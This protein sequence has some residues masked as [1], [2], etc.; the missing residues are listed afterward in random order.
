MSHNER[1]ATGPITPEGK[2]ISSQNAT[3]RG[4]TSQMPGQGTAEYEKVRARYFIEYKPQSEHRRYLVELMASAKWRLGRI[5]RIEAAALDLLMDDAPI[6]PTVYHKLAAGMG[7]PRSF[8]R[9]FYATATPPSAI[10]ARRIRNLRRRKILYKTNCRTRSSSRTGPAS[11]ACRTTSNGRN[12]TPRSATLSA[13]RT[14]TT[15]LPAPEPPGSQT[16]D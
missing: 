2:R 5:D 14:R 15:S 7:A 13:A 10:I 11:R 4:L 3:T 1:H 12:Y 16:H 9:S 6:E 8:P